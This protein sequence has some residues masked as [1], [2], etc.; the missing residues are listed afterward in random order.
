[1]QFCA[2]WRKSQIAAFLK[3]ADNDEQ[4]NMQG[5]RR[6]NCKRHCE[7][8]NYRKKRNATTLTSLTTPKR[9]QFLASSSA[10]CGNNGNTFR[11]EFAS[12]ET[13]EIF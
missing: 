4:P 7:Y 11:E 3:K 8:G 13:F 2:Y 9:N 1:M 5:V 12:A 6:T 10:H